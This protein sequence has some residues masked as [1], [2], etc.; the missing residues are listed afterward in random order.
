MWGR[1]TQRVVVFDQSSGSP[2]RTHTLN[3]P[4]PE[5]SQFPSYRSELH[6]SCFLLLEPRSPPP[7]LPIPAPNGPCPGGF[8]SWVPRIL[9]T[10]GET[11]GASLHSLLAETFQTF[12]QVRQLA[13][14]FFKSLLGSSIVV[15]QIIT[16]IHINCL[17]L[18]FSFSLLLSPQ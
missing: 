1:G 12:E 14:I 9:P 2:P 16:L 10:P 6:F 7:P 3:L 11:E 8:C 17:C 13:A 5:T 18:C 15:T 4:S